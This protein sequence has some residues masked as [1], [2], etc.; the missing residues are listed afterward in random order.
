LA[1]QHMLTVIDFQCQSITVTN[2]HMNKTA[3]WLHRAYIRTTLVE[4]MLTVQGQ[5]WSS[6]SMGISSVDSAQHSQNIPLQWHKMQQSD[7]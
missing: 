5:C 1:T 6:W 7:H 2:S 3:T 4:E